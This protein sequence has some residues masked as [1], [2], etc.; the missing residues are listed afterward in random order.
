MTTE[1]LTTRID[2]DPITGDHAVQ[3]NDAIYTPED[4]HTAWSQSY[5]TLY[6]LLAGLTSDQLV[7]QAMVH[8]AW[9]Q[10]RT[11]AA[12]SLDRVLATFRSFVATFD[13]TA[14]IA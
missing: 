6:T 2:L 8:A 14:P 4:L 11:R 9:L 7:Q 12:V 5:A 10:T 1:L 3:I 13:P